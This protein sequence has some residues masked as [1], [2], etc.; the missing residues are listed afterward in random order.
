MDESSKL[1]MTKLEPYFQYYREIT[2]S[3]VSD[4]FPPDEVQALRS[5]DD[6]HDIIVL[7]RSK[8]EARLQELTEEYF[9]KR[10]EDKS[11]VP[12]DEKQAF[13][14][15]LR[16]IMMVS[17]S[18]EGQAGGSES[19]IWKNEQS[20]RKLV[21]TMFPVRDHPDLN[22]PDDSL[23]D[24][25]SALKATRLKKVAGVSFRGTDDLRNH[26]RL[27]PKTGIIELYHHTAFL[28]ECLKASKEADVE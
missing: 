6:L 3:Y 2:A 9:L 10:Q 12:E 4:A 23:P 28:K 19:S 20:A 14:L 1:E 25:M 16:A 24:I 11:T 5:H 13:S 26:L 8:P 17:C 22:E 18:C 15:A 7:I 27:D 21:L